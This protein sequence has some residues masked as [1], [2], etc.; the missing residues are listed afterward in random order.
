LVLVTHNTSAVI[1]FGIAFLVCGVFKLLH[2][3]WLKT[4]GKLRWSTFWTGIFCSFGGSIL[5]AETDDWRAVSHPLT[6]TVFYAFTAIAVSV[7]LSNYYDVVT[8]S[9]LA[10]AQ[11]GA[12]DERL[13]Y[14]AT[15]LFSSA[16][17]SPRA[18]HVTKSAPSKD[19]QSSIQ[20]GSGSSVRSYSQFSDGSS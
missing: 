2:S 10:N 9:A 7:L 18:P 5:F 20:S 4:D 1:A 19:E 14:F 17:H 16:S 8:G 12:G 13:F 15:N 11:I 6:L 3:F